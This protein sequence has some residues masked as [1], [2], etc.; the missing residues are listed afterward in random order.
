MRHARF[1]R[2]GQGINIGPTEQHA[3]RAEGQQTYN[4]HAGAHPGIGKHCQ[5][6]ADRIHTLGSARAVGMAPSSCLPP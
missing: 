3:F 1:A 2:R 6:V 4:V 5:I